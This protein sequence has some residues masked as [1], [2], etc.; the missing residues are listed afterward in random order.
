MDKQEK[1]VRLDRI[2]EAVKA[3][4]VGS[5]GELSLSSVIGWLAYASIR[6]DAADVI[7]CD[8]EECGADASPHA[9]SDEVEAYRDLM[10]DGEYDFDISMEGLAAEIGEELDED[11]NVAINPNDHRSW[12]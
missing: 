12:L 8:I 6:D 10:Q 2:L 5:N 1:R 11:Y 9:P 3:E 4:M 7:K